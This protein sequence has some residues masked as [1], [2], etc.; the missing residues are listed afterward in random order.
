MTPERIIA[1]SQRI[2]LSV[3]FFQE[4]GCYLFFRILKSYFPSAEAYYNQDHVITKI[5]DK[6][7]DITGTV[8]GSK[9]EPIDEKALNFFEGR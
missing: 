9:H 5:G 1:V 6:F 4:G 2:P 7:Y 8:D 3:R